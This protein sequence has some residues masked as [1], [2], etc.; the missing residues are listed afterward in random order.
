MDDLAHAADQFVLGELDGADLSMIAAEALARGIDTPALVELACLH[1]TDCSTAPDLFR[2][3]MAELGLVHDWR[4]REV[5]VRVRRAREHATSLLADDSAMA[6]H[7]GGIVVELIELAGY[8]DPPAPDMEDLARGFDVMSEYLEFA[9]CESL[10][11]QIR[12]ACRN[13][14]AGPPYA[15]VNPQISTASPEQ[16]SVRPT[17]WRR[18][19]ASLWSRRAVSAAASPPRPSVLQAIHERCCVPR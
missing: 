6:Y 9:D 19:T 12:Q 17:R 18:F 3:A 2:T 16:R 5:D 15:P 8:P 13:L 11:E 10:R 14:L 1:R 4:A 7:L